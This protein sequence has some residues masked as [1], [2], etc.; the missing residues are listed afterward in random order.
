MEN[1]NRD[2]EETNFDIEELLK[3]YED[4][5]VENKTIYLD[6]EEV[7]S[8][9]SEYCNNEQFEEALDVILYG[10]KLH[11][12]SEKLCIEATYI[13]IALKRIN[14]AESIFE[15]LSN[16]DDENYIILKAKL[17]YEKEGLNATNAYLSTHYKKAEISKE[18]IYFTTDF[19]DSLKEDKHY[20]KWLKKGI[21]LF[22]DDNE[23]VE[24]LANHYFNRK[25]YKE[26]IEPYNTLL[27]ID[28][29]N[30]E[31]WS[32]LAF[33]YYMTDDFEK[34]LDACDYAITID[35]N[36]HDAYYYRAISFL[37]LGNIKEAVANYK[38]TNADTLSKIDFFIG[39]KN[40]LLKEDRVSES[41]DLLKEIEQL[42]LKNESDQNVLAQ[43]YSDLALVLLSKESTNEAL[44]YN[45]K[46]LKISPNS[47]LFWLTEGNIHKFREEDKEMI[48][49]FYKVTEYST[50]FHIFSAISIQLW[51]KKKYEEA[52][53]ILCKYQELDLDNEEYEYCCLVAN[54]IKGVISFSKANMEAGLDGDNNDLKK[55]AIYLKSH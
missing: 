3:R 42:L 10:L 32:N 54:T 52:I 49:A 7:S 44:D 53:N 27:D 37:K 5:I 23:F 25:A 51:G 39:A 12:N 34:A 11:P 14:E 29:Y 8:I 48:D 43:V 21:D 35:E 31:Y 22:N 46:A 40:D 9:G 15:K 2:E 16:E 36:Y 18:F 55:L 19:Y 6:V 45:H 50:D 26:A 38:H 1:N 28:P 20:E 4:S 41:Y 17:L 13:Y 33:C 24:D 47:E 30:T